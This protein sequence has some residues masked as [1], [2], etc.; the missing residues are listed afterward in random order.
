MQ[1]IG[2]LGILE[3]AIGYVILHACNVEPMDVYNVKDIFN[4]IISS[5]PIVYLDMASLLM[6]IRHKI[7]VFNARKIA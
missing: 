7:L 4:L 2:A 6:L 5:A 3:L 1:S